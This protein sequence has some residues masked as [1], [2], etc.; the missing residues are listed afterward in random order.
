VSARFV[1][2]KVLGALATLAFV[3]CFNFFRS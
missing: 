2:G 3:V 1:T